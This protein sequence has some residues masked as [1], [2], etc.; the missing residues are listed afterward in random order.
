MVENCAYPS[1]IYTVG[2]SEIYCELVTL[3]LLTPAGS[4]GDVLVDVSLQTGG[5]NGTYT[6]FTSSVIYKNQDT[7]PLVETGFPQ[8]SKGSVLGGYFI[9]VRARYLTTGTASYLPQL[10]ADF[11]GV[12]VLTDPLIIDADDLFVSSFSVQVPAELSQSAGRVLVGIYQAGATNSTSLLNFNFTYEADTAA[13][14]NFI[15]PA[16]VSA[17]GG[18]KLRLETAYFNVAANTSVDA[19]FGGQSCT[20]KVISNEHISLQIIELQ[21][22]FVDYTA[23]AFLP[24][25]IELRHTV[26]VESIVLQGQVDL[27]SLPSLTEDSPQCVGG[28]EGV[29]GEFMMIQVKLRNVDHNYLA[30][31]GG[32]SICEEVVVN[33]GSFSTSIESVERENNVLSVLTIKSPVFEVSGTVKVELLLKGDT[34]FRPS[35]HIDVIAATDPKL[36]GDYGALYVDYTVFDHCMLRVSMRALYDTKAV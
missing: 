24:I 31:C 6:E 23:D 35:F 32:T 28:C 15:T 36:I 11:N 30:P 19:Y 29:I 13:T 16:E 26:G 18:T 25:T 5:I 34:R 12:R 33:F 2:C 27:F 17:I 8:P 10:E 1:D 21:T 9:S 3:V 20:A 4:V 22:L 14:L 7:T